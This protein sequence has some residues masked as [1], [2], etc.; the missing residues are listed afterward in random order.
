[1]DS[2]RDI[3]VESLNGCPACGEMDVEQLGYVRDRAS[4]VISRTHDHRHNPLAGIFQCNRCYRRFTE[5]AIHTCPDASCQWTSKDVPILPF[6][7]EVTFRNRGVLK[8]VLTK[9]TEDLSLR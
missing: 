2:L 1:M 6:I 5:A 7:Q 8:N 9:K 4:T 3:N